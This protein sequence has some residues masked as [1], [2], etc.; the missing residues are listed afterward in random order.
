MVKDQP[1]NKNWSNTLFLFG[2]AG[3]YIYTP[4]KEK[5]YRKKKKSSK[6]LIATMS[7]E[8]RGNYWLIMPAEKHDDASSYDVKSG[9][10]LS[11]DSSQATAG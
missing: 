5:K 1:L 2:S 11:K 9:S 4:P 8:L 6:I 7:S 3:S 10:L